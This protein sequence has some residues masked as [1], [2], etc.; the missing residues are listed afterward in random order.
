MGDYDLQSAAPRRVWV[1]A[2]K[3]SAPGL[4]FAPAAPA[5]VERHAE[6]ENVEPNNQQHNPIVDELSQRRRKK[7]DP[8]NGAEE[9]EVNP[10]KIPAGARAMIEL[11]LLAEPADAECH[12]AHAK[13]QPWR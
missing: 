1:S 5:P 9:R 8:R 7:R 2:T 10:G 11:D 6:Q 4:V 13:D 3:S 12:Q